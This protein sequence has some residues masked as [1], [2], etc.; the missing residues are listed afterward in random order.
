MIFSFR[1]WNGKKQ[2]KKGKVFYYRNCSSSKNP[3]CVTK[4]KAVANK[5]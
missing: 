3:F 5:S 1:L 4:K 2:I